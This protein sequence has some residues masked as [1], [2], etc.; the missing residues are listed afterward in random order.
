[1]TLK[2]IKVQKD[3][4]EIINFMIKH[5]IDFPG[6]KVDV[7]HIET[8]L[9][10][11]R[12]YLLA[13][14]LNDIVIGYALAY[15]FPS[16]YAPGYLAYLYDI[17]VLE[18]HRKKGAGRLLIETLLRYLKSDGVTE[19]WLGTAIDNIEGQALFRSTGGIKSGEAFNDF[20]YEL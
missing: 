16:I 4:G 20:T 8:V 6:E 3:D 15:R 10:D 5:L 14:I 7:R 12:T 18:T 11:D 13:A 17:E 19:L 9:K 1:M 2:V